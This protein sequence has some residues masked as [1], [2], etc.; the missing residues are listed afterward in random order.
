[1]PSYLLFIGHEAGPKPSYRIFP[2]TSGFEILIARI[3]SS[4][5]DHD[6]FPEDDM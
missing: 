3:L 1:M 6:E 4:E 5:G 2:Y